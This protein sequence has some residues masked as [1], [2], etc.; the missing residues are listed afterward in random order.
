[1]RW[2]DF[3]PSVFMANKPKYSLFIVDRNNTKAKTKAGVLFENEWGMTLV[4]NPGITLDYKMQSDY[5]LTVKEDKYR[6]TSDAADSTDTKSEA[7]NDGDPSAKKGF[8]D[9]PF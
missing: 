5:F 4:L 8:S 7:A 1:V 3:G 2:R 6:P 9:L